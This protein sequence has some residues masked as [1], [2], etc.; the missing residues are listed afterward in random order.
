LRSEFPDVVSHQ[1]A[2]GWA[3]GT[4]YQ[5]LAE[6]KPPTLQTSREALA[7]AAE[8]FSLRQ[9]SMPAPSPG[10]QQRFGAVPS[11]AGART[12][13]NEVRLDASQK[14][15]ALARWPSLDEHDAYARMAGLMR[16]AASSDE[17]G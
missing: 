7:K 17:N 13:S 1:A 4:Y 8:R 14:K 9:P 11:Q 10:V 6:G 12:S 3:R 16:K 15:M 5:M 2:M